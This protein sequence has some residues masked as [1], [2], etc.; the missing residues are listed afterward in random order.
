M[1]KY[2]VCNNKNIKF[3]QKFVVIIEW[4]LENRE[5]MWSIL[6]INVIF[7]ISIHWQKQP[8]LLY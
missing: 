1:K 3:F 6:N 5:I 8:L 2:E 7:K 4:I